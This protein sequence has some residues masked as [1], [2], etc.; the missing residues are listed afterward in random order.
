MVADDEGKMRTISLFSGQDK[1]FYIS[2]FIKANQ[3]AILSEQ[4]SH[5]SDGKMDLGSSSLPGKLQLMI[6]NYQLEDFVCFNTYTCLYHVFHIF[7]HS[8][9]PLEV[10]HT[11]SSIH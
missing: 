2:T 9:A 4:A 6:H 7:N 11:T 5:Y 3:L 10:L 1:I 8:I